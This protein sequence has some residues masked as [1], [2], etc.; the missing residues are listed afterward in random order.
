MTQLE[1]RNKT[2][3]QVNL[4]G[5]ST[6]SELAEILD[7]PVK[8][9]IDTSQKGYRSYYVQGKTK[10]RLIEEPNVI[11]KLL[12]KD[13]KEILFEKFDCP[14][15][16][17]CWSGGNNYLNAQAHA[18]Q[19]A[20]VTTDISSFFTNSKA[21]YVRKFFK[22]KL[23]ISGEALDMMVQM[24]TYKGH[25]PTGA[26]TSSILAFLSHKDLFDEIAE[27]MSKRDITFTLYVDDITLSAKHGI[28]RE[29]I[30]FIKSVLKKHKLEIKTEKTKFFS[31]KKAMITGFYLA[32]G[33]K[34]S[35][36]DSVGHKVVSLL[37][38]KNLGDMSKKELR[39]LIG[40]I[41]YC[42]TADKRSFLAT[43]RNAIKA[44]KRLDKKEKEKSNA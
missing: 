21:C 4:Y 10:K 31:F 34:I 12:L 43:K 26:P 6:L 38:E 40:L 37:R 11:L 32:Q 20:F 35:V 8:N 5:I 3:K 39:R 25:I 16:N 22:E 17:K 19:H 2:E 7:F 23:K 1:T 29:E 44:L 27:Y 13:L 28:T 36:P 15:Y 24:C 33:G 18:G 42:Q 41:N 14:E 9:L 30:R